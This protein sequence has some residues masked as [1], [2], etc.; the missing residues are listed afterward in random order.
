MKKLL[1]QF[2]TDAH[3]SVFDT[4][5]AY[6]GGAD[7]VI[8]HGNLTPDNVGAL[9]DGTIFTRA[10]K[11]KKNTAI[12]IG[13]SNMA[14]G[15]KLLAAVQKHFFPGFQVSVML[16]SNGSNTTAAAAVA[17]LAGSAP[18]AGKKAVVLAG[19]GPVGQRAA[20]MMALEG[21]EVSITSRHIFN[22][23]KA[24]FAMKQRF[25]VDITPV[26][27]GDYDSRAAAIADANVVLATGA[28]GVELLKPEHWQN[29][30]HLQLLADA[31]ATPPVG[32]GGTN[33][34]DKGQE[35]H[36]KIVWGAIGFGA[37]KLALH[38]ACIA[39]LFEDNKQ[40]FD[41]EIIFALAKE[42]A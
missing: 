28:A 18:L 36:G 38:R 29:N 41:A 25:D 34:M 33:V 40:V 9:V 20:A 37:L 15:Q 27:A 5:V 23:E 13:G 10:P 17:K 35:R 31:N 39:K 22:A 4:V 14:A 7:H 2:D 30:P 6:D 21:A 24:C 42:M 32:I 1:F 3:P 16:D 12:F 11:D 26:E 8:G 19:T